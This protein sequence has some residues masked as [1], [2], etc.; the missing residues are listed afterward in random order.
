MGR[1]YIFTLQFCILECSEYL[2]LLLFQLSG[3]EHLYWATFRLRPSVKII[4][5]PEGKKE[6]R[7]KKEKEKRDSK[8]LPWSWNYVLHLAILLK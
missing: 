5:F 2:P 4:P 8:Q 7:K 3:N 1:S 6:K